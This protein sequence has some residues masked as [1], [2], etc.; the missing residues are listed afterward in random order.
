MEDIPPVILKKKGVPSLIFDRVIANS[1]IED[2]HYERWNLFSKLISK[3]NYIQKYGIFI[4]YF[5]WP[6]FIKFG[7]Q[8]V[9]QGLR[10]PLA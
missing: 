5:R 9:D 3:F 7:M 2:M 4:E 1:M 10:F 6:I 8:V